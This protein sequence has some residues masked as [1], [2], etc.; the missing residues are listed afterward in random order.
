MSNI[1]ARESA[2]GSY[3]FATANRSGRN[4]ETLLREGFLPVEQEST[5]GLELGE[6]Q[7]FKRCHRLEADR[8]VRYYEVVEDAQLLQQEIERLTEELASSDYKIVKSFE[9]SLSGEAI[10]C[11]IAPLRATRESLRSSIRTLRERLV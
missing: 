11:D 9:E 1:Y 4:V 5:E 2:E 8:V 7:S 10:S 6:F 3:E